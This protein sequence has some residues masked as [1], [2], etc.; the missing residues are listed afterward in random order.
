MSSPVCVL[1]R[2]SAAHAGGGASGAPR[3]S[4]LS[5][6]KGSRVFMV[7]GTLLVLAVA[8]MFLAPPQLG[9]ETSYVVTEGV[10][11]LPRFHA[12]D[13]VVL[14]KEANYHVGEVA[15]YHNQQLGEVVMHRIIAINE[16]RYVF[17]GDNNQFPDSYEPV[18]SQIV[19]AERIHVPGA[20]RIITTLR[21]P[22][23]AAVALVLMWLLSFN[24]SKSRRQRRRHRYAR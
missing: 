8:W 11:M 21:I 20:G 19:G 2:T 15:A 6:I 12:G 3:P 24:R 14:R 18:A 17:K 22:V 13:L 23:V 16:S 7:L 1:P 9:G 10:S 4:T 5:A